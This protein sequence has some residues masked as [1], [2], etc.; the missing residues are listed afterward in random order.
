MATRKYSMKTV[1]LGNEIAVLT[2]AQAKE[3]ND[4]L[5]HRG[6]PGCAGILIQP[7]T[8]PR[9]LQATA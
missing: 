4:Y 6:G 9:P 8:P 5:R 1:R 2:I 3:L 7:K